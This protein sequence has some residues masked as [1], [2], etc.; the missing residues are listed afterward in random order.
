MRVD[1]KIE[2]YDYL[3][4]LLGKLDFEELLLAGW[5]PRPRGAFQVG[6]AG[7]GGSSQEMD[8]GFSGKIHLEMDDLGEH[9]SRNWMIFSGRIHLESRNG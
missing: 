7:I 6:L 2:I 9:L 4:S 3:G 5:R 8:D 1:N